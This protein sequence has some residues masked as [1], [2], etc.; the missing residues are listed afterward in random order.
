M[1]K[2]GRLAGFC[3][4]LSFTARMA[5]I[6]QIVMIQKAIDSEGWK[7][8]GFDSAK[9]FAREVTG[10]SYE[11]FQ[12]KS[13]ELKKLGS[14]VV[15]IVIGLGLGIKDVRMIEHA[16]ITDEKSGKKGLRVGDDQF[17]P[18]DESRKDELQTAIDLLREQRDAAKKDAKHAS[19]KVDAVSREHKKE[20]DAMQKE[21]DGLKAAIPSGEDD[22]AWA[23]KYLAEIAAK[24]QAWDFALR[25]LAMHKRTLK[26]P[27][28]QAK[29]IGLFEEMKTRLQQFS[30]DFD[31]VLVE[32]EE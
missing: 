22:A 16:L 7:G 17:I 4:G 25:A 15:S 32:G 26:D 27:A 12:K 23:A 5:E 24:A 10:G 11:A 19:S 20:I 2:K 30:D 9:D 31:A 13:A 8:E 29:V 18:L 21:I 14:D 6:Q 28:L 1:R 3:Q